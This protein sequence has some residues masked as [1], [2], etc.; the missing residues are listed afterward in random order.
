MS[1]STFSFKYPPDTEIV[2]SWLLTFQACVGK[3]KCAIS[4]TNDVLGDPCPRVVKEL[5]VEA[6]CSAPSRTNEPRDDM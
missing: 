3:D 1:E 4:V 6:E 2:I 5:A